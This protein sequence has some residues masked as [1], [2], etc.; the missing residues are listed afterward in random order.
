MH[1]RFFHHAK[2]GIVEQGFGQ[3]AEVVGGPDE[4]G[5]VFHQAVDGQVAGLSLIHI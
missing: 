4:L 2:L 5:F 3:G 1:S